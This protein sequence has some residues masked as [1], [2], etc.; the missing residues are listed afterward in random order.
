MSQSD[1]VYVL[2]W[3]LH[4]IGDIH[5][6]LHAMQRFD[7]LRPNGDRGGNEI[8][9]RTGNLHAYWD[10]RIGSGDTDR[11]LTQLG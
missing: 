6:P 9:L 8:E 2:P 4:L 5:Q 3:L 10:S 1:Q 11:F 7:R